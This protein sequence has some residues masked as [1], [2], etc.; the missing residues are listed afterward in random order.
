MGTKTT[1]DNV[2]ELVIG[3]SY[4]SKETGPTGA[5]QIKLKNFMNGVIAQSGDQDCISLDRLKE[6]DRVVPGDVVIVTGFDCGKA[7]RIVSDGWTLAA[8]ICRART[9]NP[10]TLRQTF[11]SWVLRYGT[12]YD[13]MQALAHGSVVKNISKPDIQNAVFHLPSI[14][15]QDD[16]ASRL[17]KLQ[18][19]LNALEVLLPGSDDDMRFIYNA[20]LN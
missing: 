17:E 8:H 5:F 16:V 4:S 11:L 1:L 12:F 14:E 7:A 18:V 10:A 15:V 13:D 9:K 20:Y 6:K 2:A 19:R 3:T